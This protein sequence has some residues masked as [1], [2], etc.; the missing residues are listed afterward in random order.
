M[1]IKPIKLLETGWTRSMLLRCWYGVIL[2]GLL[3]GLGM[4]WDLGMGP[5]AY[6]QAGTVIYNNSNMAGQDLSGGIYEGTSFVSTN[7]RHANLSQ[8]NFRGAIFTK[9]NLSEANLAGSN[10]TGALLDLTNLASAD[11]QDTLLI[12]IISMRADW[13]GADVTGADFTDALLDRS[14]LNVICQTATGTNSITGQ[15]TRQ[16]LGCRD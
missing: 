4:G 10:L 1:Q 15:D 5:P 9:T 3:L 16:S 13:T 14:A 11:L 6:A 7:L 2:V 12:G 8:A